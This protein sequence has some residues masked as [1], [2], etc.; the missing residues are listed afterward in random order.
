MT[1]PR[2][3]LLLTGGG[4]RGAFQAGAV[5]E[6][7]PAL[8]AAGTRPTVLVGTSVGALNAVALAA[9]AH[10]DAAT[11]GAAL[12]EQWGSVTKARVLQPLWRQ[13]PM[14]AL[15][16]G[17]ETLGLPRLRLRGLMGVAPLRATVHTLV[18]WDQMHRNVAA[19]VVDAVAVTAASVATGRTMAF[20][21]R[22][23]PPPA[24]TASTTYVASRLDVEHVM[25]SAA[26]PMLFPPAWIDDPTDAAGWYVDGSTRLHTPLKPALDL[27]VDRLVV[28]GASSL[29]DGRARRRDE[30]AVDLGDT[31]VTLLHAMLDDSLRR[32]VRRL[33]EVN[34]HLVGDGPDHVAVRR[35]RTAQ[36]RPPYRTVPY[37][38][39]APDDPDEIGDV[40]LDVFRRRYR[41]WRG[42]RDPDVEAIH[43]LLGGN[44]PLQGEL[45]SFVLFDQEFHRELI[46]LG[47]AAAK[48]WLAA[49]PDLWHTGPLDGSP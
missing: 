49:H 22:G 26:I 7:L 3:G 33:G 20:V 6:L 5:A 31:A 16:Y 8:A 40:A 12:V 46:A 47:R 14:V 32:D 37:V 19:G 11:Q 42:V 35:Q 48:R 34:A 9:T 13:L 24:A 36:G 28:V 41:G 4:A 38:A 25:G 27:G 43:R 18:D 15:R 2:V 29:D 44:S 17:G 21:E 45:L 1:T 30:R 10:L 23:A 39:V